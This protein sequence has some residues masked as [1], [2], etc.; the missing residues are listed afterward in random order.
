[1][2]SLMFTEKHHFWTRKT[3]VMALL[4]DASLDAAAPEQWHGMVD[5]S[6]ARSLDGQAHTSVQLAVRNATPFVRAMLQGA[7]AAMLEALAISANPA[8]FCTAVLVVDARPDNKTDTGGSLLLTPAELA[9]LLVH[10][11]STPKRAA[12]GAYALQ[13]LTRRNARRIILPAHLGCE[14]SSNP[15]PASVTDAFYR[16]AVHKGEDDYHKFSYT[17]AGFGYHATPGALR[18]KRAVLDAAR[19]AAA[20]AAR[21]AAA[22]AA[23]EAAA[24]EARR[25]AAEQQ[26]R[27]A[28]AAAATARLRARGASATCDL[29]QHAVDEVAASGPARDAAKAAVSKKDLG[30]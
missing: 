4:D 24:A 15:V 2:L 7:G 23:R 5:V 11:W 28:A 25:Q 1:M 29:R 10:D 14:W 27:E 26:Q 17:D 6:A 8:S 13:L 30:A 21:A 12:A 20:A 16:S 9:A 22:Q 18:R 19:E 3:A